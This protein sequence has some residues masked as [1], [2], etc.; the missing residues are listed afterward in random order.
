MATTMPFELSVKLQGIKLAKFKWT[1]GVTSINYA[2]HSAPGLITMN[3]ISCY[4]F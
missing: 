4:L 2:L 1:F 3:T